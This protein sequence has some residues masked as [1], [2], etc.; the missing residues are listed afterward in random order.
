MG[1]IYL[2]SVLLL[3][4]SFILIKKTEK[5]LDI[6]SFLG[7]TIV[8]IMGYNALLS[9][10]FSFFN[11]PITL[12]SLSISNFVFSDIIIFI[13]YRKKQTQKYKFDKVN[14]ICIC[15]ILLVTICVSL[16]NF[17]F[18][19]NIKY[20]TGDPATHYYTSVVFAGQDR[21]LSRNIDKVYE[22][23]HGR[24]IASY[25]NSGILMKCLSGI[26]NEIDFYNIFIAFGIFILF[27][28]GAVMYNTLEKFTKSMGGKILALIVS[29][30]YVLGYPLNSFL[31]GFE[32][33][34]LGLLVIRNNN[35]YDI[36]F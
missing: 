8:L 26:V 21:L 31:F 9:Y 5:K 10:I 25:V 13:I 27:M 17:G 1:V 19:F 33:M 30:I 11:I 16:I 7:I 29:L 12:L 34:S 3:S 35:T 14:C 18:P 24:K 36:L 4:V 22:V 15:I 2:L 6:L 32:Y 28:T 23:F 20:E